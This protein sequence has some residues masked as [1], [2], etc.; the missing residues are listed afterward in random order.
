M[1]NN[2]SIV[3]DSTCQQGREKLSKFFYSVSNHQE[4]FRIGE[5]F[6]RDY[7]KGI[8]SFAISSTGYQTSQQTTILGIASF[9]DHSEELRIA[10]V[11]DSLR[12]GA[13]KDLL[14]VS[15]QV[16]FTEAA[17][18]VTI[19]RFYNHFDF[20]DLDELVKIN[21]DAPEFE[22]FL[23]CLLKNYDA[24]FWNVPE[25]HKLQG[26]F[27]PYFQIIKRFESLSI[28]VSRAV[29]S[30]KQVDEIKNFFE[31]YGINLKGLLLDIPG[32]RKEKETG[33]EKMRKR[34]WRRS[35]T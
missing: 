35:T 5:S 7:K 10:I 16:K 1:K 29:S 30:G 28:I 34:W 27:S 23:E 14:H 25:L 33:P 4:L 2:I 24:V 21:D 18:E 17:R 6:F 31:G 11:S 22:H 20:V 8:K 26:G 15:E 13:F 19:Q 12:D 3:A 32:S 9:F